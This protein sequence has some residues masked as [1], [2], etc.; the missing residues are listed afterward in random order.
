MLVYSCACTSTCLCT[1]K[2]LRLSFF[3]HLITGPTL[4]PSNSELRKETVT[5]CVCVYVCMCVCVYVWV[6]VLAC[7]RTLACK[8]LVH[9]Y[10]SNTYIHVENR[11][12]TK[13]TFMYIYLTDRRWF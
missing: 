12:H 9:E 6:G 8:Q 5:L 10:V 4:E 1:S 11:H 13:F 3:R 2:T 7:L